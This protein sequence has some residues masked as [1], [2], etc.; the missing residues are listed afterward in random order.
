MCY[1]TLM[2]KILLSG[3]VIGMFFFYGLHQQ[4]ETSHVQVVVPT[5][6]QTLPSEMPTAFPTQAAGTQPPLS[7]TA[8]PA[9]PTRIP[10]GQ[11]RNGVYTGSP[12]DAFYG[13][14]QVQA[15]ITNGKISDISFLQYPNDRSTSIMIN[16][17]AMPYLKQEAIQAQSAQVDII[18]G[19]T[20]SS[21]AFRQSLQSALAQAH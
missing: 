14:I 3:V 5:H 12:A 7:P 9:A 10:K 8:M 1:A 15:A 17:Q 4:E 2:K 16:Q 21:M 6:L 19:A 11:Y 20:D 13:L 18:S